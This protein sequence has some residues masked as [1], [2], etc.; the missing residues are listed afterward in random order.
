MIQDYG[1]IKVK[2]SDLEFDKENPNEL[3][4][5]Q[6]ESLKKSFRKFGNVM[7]I[8]ID[9][10]NFIVHGNHRAEIYQQLGL[11]EIPAFRREFKDDDERRLCSQA[12]NKLHGEYEKIKDANQLVK[13][14]ESNRLEELVELIAKP[15]ESLL[16]IIERHQDNFE[17]Q[18]ISA[19]DDIKTNTKCPKCGY[20]W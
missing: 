16:M 12:M 14:F 19:L 18:E 11:E 15:K 1:L 4:K 7:P 5:E 20:E 6:Q 9:Q 2:L 17:S 13:L 10:N 8:L 3:T